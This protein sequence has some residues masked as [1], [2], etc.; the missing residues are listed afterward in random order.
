MSQLINLKNPWFI[1]V[2][3]FY[4]SDNFSEEL[5]LEY[6]KTLNIIFTNKTYKINDIFSLKYNIVNEV[7]YI[8]LELRI[9]SNDD[10]LFISQE[11]II[12]IFNNLNID[13]SSLNLDI[14]SNFYYFICEN[15]LDLKFSDKLLYDIYYKKIDSF[16]YIYSSVDQN[17]FIINFL[18]HIIKFDIY[19]SKIL[20]FYKKFSIT[21]PELQKSNFKLINDYSKIIE[22]DISNLNNSHLQELNKKINS[23]QAVNFWLMYDIESLDSNLENLESRLKSIWGMESRYFLNHIEKAKFI[24]ESFDSILKKNNLIKENILENYINFAKNSIEQQKLEN[25]KKKINHIKNIKELISWLAFIEIFINWLSEASKIFS[26][27][28]ALSKVLQN[29]AFMRMSLI[30]WFI[31]IYFLY[32]FIKILKTKFKKT[33]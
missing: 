14:F 23:L 18:K 16:R 13:F 6:F 15:F 1:N 25:D 19:Y 11:E 5:F 2:I 9:I 20:N 8:T 22:W 28:P 10:K 30:F 27:N 32:Y 24:I 12:N 4:K 21:Y 26:F 3:T 17:E 33:K 7:D 31:I 29:T